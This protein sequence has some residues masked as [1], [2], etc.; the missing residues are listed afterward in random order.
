MLAFD[1]TLAD[2]R[3]EK[4]RQAAL[5]ANLDKP[6]IALERLTQQEADLIAQQAAAAAEAEALTVER[7]DAQQTL[8]RLDTM[9]A[10]YAAADRWLVAMQA[11][12]EGG[13]FGLATHAGHT[14]Q[15]GKR[16][17]ELQAATRAKLV[18]IDRR[19]KELDQ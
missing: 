2:I 6:R 9:Q 8:S 11:M 1:Q 14:R 5:L 13:Y 15:A 19:L 4:A 12:C 17:V 10:D 3:K 18:D 16:A 7:A